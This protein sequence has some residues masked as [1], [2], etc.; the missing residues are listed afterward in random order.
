MDLPDRWPDRVAVGGA[1]AR[2]GFVRGVEEQL[3]GY[4]VGMGLQAGGEAGV[5]H[6]VAGALIV[7]LEEADLVPAFGAE[8]R[9]DLGGYTVAL[10]C[11]S[12]RPE[13]NVDIVV[14]L[15]QAA[16]VDAFTSADV[17]M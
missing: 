13:S 17:G 8:M 6:V 10:L 14:G 4:L 3:A 2:A 12:V 7:D 1:I 9:A 15:G 16:A 11:G 5:D